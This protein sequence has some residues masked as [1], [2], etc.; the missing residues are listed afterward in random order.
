MIVLV[1]IILLFGFTSL[2][3]EWEKEIKRRGRH[4]GG[5]LISHNVESRPGDIKV[6]PLFDALITGRRRA[7]GVLLRIPIVCCWGYAY[8]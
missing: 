5:I 7:A 1:K 2:K 6:P 8:T 4:R 3:S